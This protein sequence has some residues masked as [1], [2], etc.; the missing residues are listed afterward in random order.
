[1]TAED[2]ADL[3]RAAQG[4]DTLAMHELLDRLAPY[5]ARICGPIAL[6][7]GADAAQET[8][9]A[10][11]TGLRGLREPAT[12]YGWVRAIAVREAVRAARR[13]TRATP[14]AP[15]DL[16]ALPAREDP[17]LAADVWDVLARLHP[18]QRAVLVLRDLEDL[19]EQTAAALLNLPAGTVKSRL[20]RARRSFRRAW[21]R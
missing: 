16:A 12:L 13:D 10:V 14:M 8:L 5:V 2:P 18:E 11:F 21:D 19:D 15:G 3:V 4:G 6:A 20:H 17:E 1:M 7:S 9:V